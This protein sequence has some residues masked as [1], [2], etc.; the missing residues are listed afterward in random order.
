MIS[1]VDATWAGPGSDW[2]DSANWAP[3][4]VPDGTA[5]FAGASPTSVVFSTVTTIGT[6]EFDGGS[7][8]F[9]LSSQSLTIDAAGI[10]D[11]AI[12][13]PAFNTVGLLEF[14]NSASAGD[15]IINNTPG[16]TT[17][18][19]TSTAGSA[20]ITNSGGGLL[21]FTDNSDAGSATITTNG[22]SATLFSTNSNGGLARFITN[23][24]GVMDFSGTLGPDGLNHITAGSI[25]GAGDYHLGANELTVGGNGFSTTVSG[26]IDG[27][28]GSLVKAGTVT[29]ILSGSNTYTGPTTITNGVL[30]VD[31]SIASSAVTVQDAGTLDGSGT[32]GAVTVQAGGTLSP[33]VNAGIL[34][35]G[36]AALTTDAQFTIQI[37]GTAA[38]QFDQLQV[39]G[40]IDLGG[41]TLSGSLISGFTPTNG[42]SFTIIDNDGTADAVTGTFAGIAEGGFVGIGGRA[43]QVTYAGGDG[44]DVVLTAV[45]SPPLT[46]TGLGPSVTFL[47]NTVNAAPQILDGDVTFTDVTFTG[48]TLTVSGLLLEDFV[49]IH[50]QGGGTGQIGFDADTQTVSYGGTPIGTASGGDAGNDLTVTF[51]ANAN[52]A[53]VDALIENLAYF[54]SSNSPTASRTLDMTVTDASFASTGAVPITVNVTPENELPVLDNVATDAAYTEQAAAITLSSGLVV[55]D[56]DGG[57]LVS[58]TISIGGFQSGDVLHFIDQNGIT[59]SYGAGVLTLTG[60]ATLTQYQA[61]LRS[62]TFDNLTND[63]P[64]NF[65]NN[66]TRTITWVITD[67]G[68]PNASS[69]PVTTTIAVTGI[70]E[71]PVAQNGSAS[72][73]ED[74]PITGAVIATD[75][76]NTAAQLSYS[77]VGANGGAAHGTVAVN[78]NGTFT[79]TP[80]ANF[81][82][83]DSFSF[84]ANDGSLDSNTATI[85]LTVAAVNDAP[86]AQ[87]GVAS[88]NEDTVIAGTAVA[89]D[90]DN[91]AAQLSYI[92]IGANGGAA[93]GS[94]TMNANGTFSYTPAPDFNG[95]DSFAF[96]ANDGNSNSN[97]GTM[98]I[99]VNPVN[100]APVIVSNG[101]GDT[102]SISVPQNSVAVTTVHATDTDSAT[103]TYAIAGGADQA[104]FQI[105]ATTGALSFIAAPNFEA[106]TDADGNNSYIVQVRAS[107]GSLSDTQAI[108]VNVTDLKEAVAIARPVDFN[109]DGMDDLLWRTADG[110]VSVWTYKAGLVS[111]LPTLTGSAPL[112]TTIEGT[113]DFNGDGTGDI[114]FRSADGHIAEWLMNGTQIAAARDVGTIDASWHTSG[115]GDFNGDHTD[116]I[117]FHNDA[118]QVA[119]WSMQ[120]GNIASI[121][122]AGSAGPASHIQ[123]TGDFNGDGR[124]DIL[125]RNEDG[126]V[127]TWLMNNGQASTIVDIGTA[128]ATAHIVGTGDFNGDHTEDILFRGNDGHVTAWLMTSG[129]IASIQD[130]GSA[131]ASFAL[132]GAGDL[133]GDD[134]EDILW[135]NGDGHVTVAWFL[136]NAGQLASA[137][138]IGHTPT[139]AQIGGSHFDLV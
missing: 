96:R 77:L 23:A 135:S 126:H 106:P 46:L 116:D 78:A 120:G 115:T 30:E 112:S 128:P 75:I 45:P 5:I 136:N 81:N 83:I 89:T 132:L 51:N 113:G 84:K 56:I 53:A 138:D 94:V 130:I 55:S 107:D 111:P 95:N 31:G 123:G 64:T 105:N 34:H 2:D 60:S 109:A 97:P 91:T 43:F 70:D 54:N 44:N 10:V 16:A 13:A 73:N 74:T 90:V 137:E 14:D 80:A 33:G 15:A 101:G 24:G 65:G 25:A 69:A 38:G 36:N 79:Y 22:G 119:T 98:T 32:T 37:G 66:P 139:G 19:G 58:A 8:T 104:R 117:L 18:T 93:H 131:D 133:N 59:G 1:M 20:T 39:T 134:R 68:S 17:F 121:K 103:L 102:A 42:D 61:A 124:T 50:N 87:N 122:T 71:A 27:V 26:V 92:L 41:A 57:T 49:S 47:E 29:L 6:M 86:V 114:L 67:S 110:G 100:D 40:G 76:D 72:G 7:Y 127:V 85:A 21:S 63:N 48:G 88:G 82:G 118:G 52:A 11:N 12:A 129:H 125:F 28:G 99:T 108:T 62:I 3:Q 4:T 35:T 9:D